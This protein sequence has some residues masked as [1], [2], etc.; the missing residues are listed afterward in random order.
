MHYMRLLVTTKNQHG[1]WH[2]MNLRASEEDNCATMQ[3]PSPL[4]AASRKFQILMYRNK[5]KSNDR[6]LS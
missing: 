6:S 1:P 5:A 3:W 4:D 2:R